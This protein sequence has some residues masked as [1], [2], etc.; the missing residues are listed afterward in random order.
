[1]GSDT[2]NCKNFKTYDG[3]RL[4]PQDSAPTGLVTADKGALYV[5]STYGNLY[6]WSGSA[7]ESAAGDAFNDLD[8]INVTSLQVDD[9]LMLS[10]GAWI[11]RNV[12]TTKMTMG[13]TDYESVGMNTSVAWNGSWSPLSGAVDGE[14]M[15]K[16]CP[17]GSAWNTGSLA[18]F[19]GDMTTGIVCA[20]TESGT[21]DEF[22]EF[23][24]D[25]DNG[26]FDPDDCWDNTLFEY[27]APSA[28]LYRYTIHVQVNQNID[29]MDSDNY[30]TIKAFFNSDSDSLTDTEVHE[31][32]S[33][34]IPRNTSTS[35]EYYRT[36]FTGSG[37]YSTTGSDDYKYLRFYIS[38]SR[39]FGADDPGMVEARM[40]I[41]RIGD[42]VI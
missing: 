19:Y 33:T 13:I 41:Q 38:N 12:A 5:D 2:P 30:T 42:N 21:A 36:S 20:A 4:D 31:I 14:F 40:S 16:G 11:N 18:E 7:W 10:G 22:I 6:V 8:D 23:V 28:G 26:C 39:E 35:N 32:Y 17:S 29:D 27:E 3:I 24:D 34:V 25:H 1:M 15:V 37:V 9:V